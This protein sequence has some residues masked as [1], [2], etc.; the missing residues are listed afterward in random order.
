MNEFPNIYLEMQVFTQ[1]ELLAQ[2]LDCQQSWPK[3]QVFDFELK[4]CTADQE[5]LCSM[6]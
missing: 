4:Y 3:F 5:K 2:L 1:P 6:S